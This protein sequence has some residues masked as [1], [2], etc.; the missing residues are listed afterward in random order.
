MSSIPLATWGKLSNAHPPKKTVIKGCN[1]FSNFKNSFTS[2]ILL[3]CNSLVLDIY[4]LNNHKIN[5][6]SKL[7]VAEIFF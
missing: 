4:W 7:M 5:F 6:K 2:A 1:G 3:I